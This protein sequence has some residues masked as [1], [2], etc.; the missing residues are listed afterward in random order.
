MKWVSE[1]GVLPAIE[2]LGI[3]PVHVKASR[4][5]LLRKGES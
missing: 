1:D 2:R 5:G 4:V 3:P